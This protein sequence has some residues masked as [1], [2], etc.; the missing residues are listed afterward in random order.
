MRRLSLLALILVAGLLAVGAAVATAAT[1]VAL[2]AG[3]PGVSPN[4][5]PA[6]LAAAPTGAQFAAVM[7]C[8]PPTRF[9]CVNQQCHCG[10][11]CGSKG[12]ASFTCNE[13]THVSSCTCNP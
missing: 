4:A 10:V 1:P 8:E 6:W 9:F 12:V 3:A 11:Q 13:T 5:A 2:A 7:S